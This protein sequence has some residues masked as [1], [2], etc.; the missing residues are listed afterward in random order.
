MMSSVNW[1]QGLLEDSV[2]HSPHTEGTD[3]F[4]ISATKCKIYKLNAHLESTIGCGD[5]PEH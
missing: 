2:K 5:L 3:Y 1:K 4:F